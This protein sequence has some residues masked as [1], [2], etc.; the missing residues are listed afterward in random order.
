MLT[1]S[2]SVYGAGVEKTALFFVTMF[3]LRHFIGFA[4]TVFEASVISYVSAKRNSQPRH[5]RILLLCEKPNVKISD[6]CLS[7][8]WIWTQLVSSKPLR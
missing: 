2:I 3:H 4:A 7:R 1:S 5:S 8:C 6:F